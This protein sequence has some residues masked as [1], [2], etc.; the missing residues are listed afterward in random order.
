L[1]GSLE[2]AAPELIRGEALSKAADIWSLGVVLYALVEGCFPFDADSSRF[3][4][5]KIMHEGVKFSDAKAAESMRWQP[6]I[7]AL[8]EKEPQKRP[9]VGD[10]Y[11]ILATIE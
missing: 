6:L 5:A 11:E 2:Y 8:L 1:L 7:R 3:V 10:I 4:K 9:Q